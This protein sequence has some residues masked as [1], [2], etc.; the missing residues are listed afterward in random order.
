MI[1]AKEARESSEKRIARWKTN[2]WEYI[3]S[4]IENESGFS[5]EF[6][7]L[8][9]YEL[10]DGDVIELEKLGYKVEKRYANG[11]SYIVS[12]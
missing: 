10:N 8:S 4:R 1:N 12:W 6:D 9:E 7:Y 5:V 3:E 11:T 2:K